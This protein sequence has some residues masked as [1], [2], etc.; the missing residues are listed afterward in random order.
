[1]KK[2]TLW[3]IVICAG[4]VFCVASSILAIMYSKDIYAFTRKQIDKVVS[5]KDRALHQI[6]DKQDNMDS[7][8]YGY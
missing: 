8:P 5:L 3:Y 6:T 7:V 1:V 4:A 2:S